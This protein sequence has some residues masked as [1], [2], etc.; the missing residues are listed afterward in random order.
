MTEQELL[1]LKAVI[2]L[3]A[4][5]SKLRIGGYYYN[6]ETKEEIAFDDAL[7]IVSELLKSVDNNEAKR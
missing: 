7:C 5:N 2:Y 6:R 3:A 1:A 4:A